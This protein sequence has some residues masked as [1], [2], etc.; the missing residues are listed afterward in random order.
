M[1]NVV[2]EKTGTAIKPRSSAS[3]RS[4]TAGEK[5]AEARMANKLRKKKAHRRRL[6][7]SNSK[8]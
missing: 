2:E 7:R 4:E 5:L 8:G 3:G 1:E 6:K